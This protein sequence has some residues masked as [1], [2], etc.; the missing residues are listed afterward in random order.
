MFDGIV[1]CEANDNG[2]QDIAQNFHDGGELNRDAIAN[3]LKSE[4]CEDCN[5]HESCQIHEDVIERHF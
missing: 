2:T 1:R 3:E 5:N 4:V